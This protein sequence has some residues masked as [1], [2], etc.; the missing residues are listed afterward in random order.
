MR[1]S[2]AYGY[3][4]HAD[5]HRADTSQGRGMPCPSGCLRHSPLSVQ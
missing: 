4:H 5:V 2:G 1:D 3:P